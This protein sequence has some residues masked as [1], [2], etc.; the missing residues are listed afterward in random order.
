M[1]NGSNKGTYNA[2][3]ST[4][5]YTI[6]SSSLTAGNLYSWYINLTHVSANAVQTMTNDFYIIGGSS[7]SSCVTNLGNAYFRPNSCTVYP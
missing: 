4:G 6:N 5:S 1:I 7:S 3:T 2:I